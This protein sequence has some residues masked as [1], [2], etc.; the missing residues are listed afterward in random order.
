MKTVIMGLAC[1]WAL[2][3][4][5][6]GQEMVEDA[7]DGLTPPPRR[8]FSPAKDP[9]AK[10]L[11][12]EAFHVV[13][14]LDGIDPDVRAMFYSKVPRS[15]IAN[16][17]ERFN[18]TDAVTGKAMPT[19]RL[20]MAGSAPG[21]WFVLYEHGGRGYCNH[22][23]VFAREG[24]KPWRIV[25]APAGFIRRHAGLGDLKAAVSQ[26]AFEEQPGYTYY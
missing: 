26:G 14:D 23:I 21:M 6:R 2:A 10:R 7:T 15:A 8:A 19:R 9:Y 11:A 22:L 20:V 25:A 3:P 18:A 13:E 24:D 5:G 17:G 1:L 16:R 12:G 4:I